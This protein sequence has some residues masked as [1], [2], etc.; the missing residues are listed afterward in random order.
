VLLLIAGLNLDTLRQGGL[1]C[2]YMVHL[3]LTLWLQLN[4]IG[5]SFLVD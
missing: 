5:Q 2:K 3:E 1:I 4:Q